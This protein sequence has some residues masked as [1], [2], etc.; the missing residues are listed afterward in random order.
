MP[1]SKK[2]ILKRIVQSENYQGN[3]RKMFLKVKNFTC[4]LAYQEILTVS[5]SS[6]YSFVPGH[7][8]NEIGC[9]R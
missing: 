4:N 2:A 1:P 6:A 5:F 3:W 8:I 9:S 7:E